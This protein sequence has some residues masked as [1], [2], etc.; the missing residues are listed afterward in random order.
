MRKVISS[1]MAAALIL[2]S[3]AISQEKADPKKADPKK[4]EVKKDE[5]KARGQLPSGWG[6][7]GLSEEQKQ[8]VYKLQNKYGEQIDK[9]EAQIK[10]LKE[11]LTKERLEILTPEQKK[12]LRE[13]IESKT[14]SGSST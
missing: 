14:G 5:V 8:K 2:V 3:A 12:R 7:L 6:K 10:E 11:K 13:L 1:G 4:E 9:L